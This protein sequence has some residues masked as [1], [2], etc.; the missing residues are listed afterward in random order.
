MVHMQNNSWARWQITF[1]KMI[2]SII[3]RSIKDEYNLNDIDFYTFS[4]I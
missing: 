3:I 1:L 4:Y 2:Q